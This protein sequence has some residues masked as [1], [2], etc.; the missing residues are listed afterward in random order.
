MSRPFPQVP[1]TLLQGT[2][3]FSC[4]GGSQGS[5]KKSSRLPQQQE[6]TGPISAGAGDGGE[7]AGGWLENMSL[8]RVSVTLF[9][10]LGQVEYTV[11][12]ACYRSQTWMTLIVFRIF[13]VRCGGIEEKR[14]F[15]L[16]R[17]SLP[18]LYLHPTRSI[19]K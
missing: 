18:T 4:V 8:T 10:W 7:E 17:T 15:T 13:I 19:W 16:Q 2:L 11:K 12:T 6:I 14:L 1:V 9:L 3:D 5:R